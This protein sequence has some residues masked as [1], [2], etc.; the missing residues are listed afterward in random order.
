M[1]RRVATWDGRKTQ[2]NYYYTGN[3]FPNS[4]WI[5]SYCLQHYY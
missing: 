1:N 4:V 2:R 3:F 5:H